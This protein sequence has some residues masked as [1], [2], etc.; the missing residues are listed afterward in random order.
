MYHRPSAETMSPAK[1]REVQ[2]LSSGTARAQLSN[3]N[4][5]RKCTMLSSNA[6][7]TWGRRPECRNVCAC[8]QMLCEG[9]DC[10]RGCILW[11]NSMAVHSLLVFRLRIDQMFPSFLLTCREPSCRV[12]RGLPSCLL[13]PAPVRL[14]ADRC[15]RSSPPSSC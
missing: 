9:V 15:T 12:S 1:G 10:K 11:P 2:C 3:S 4:H 5:M 7:R 8:L 13:S 14:W 6:Q